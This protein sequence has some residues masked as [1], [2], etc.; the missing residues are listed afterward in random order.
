VH[1][2]LLPSCNEFGGT[3]TGADPGAV[4]E[5]A[6]AMSPGSTSEQQSGV[7]GH[8]ATE[9]NTEESG[10]HS[11]QKD[12]KGAAPED[13]KSEPQGTSGG[14]VEG[15]E[16]GTTASDAEIQ[17]QSDVD[18]HPGQSHQGITASQTLSEVPVNRQERLFVALGGTAVIF[19]I[20]SVAILYWHFCGGGS[21]HSR[22]EW[23]YTELIENK[24]G[25]WFGLDVDDTACTDGTETLVSSA[26]ARS[27]NSTRHN[28]LETIP[29]A[30]AA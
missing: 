11:T 22:A 20:I 28:S 7:S 5:A 30:S 23:D 19:V 24:V 18:Q 3:V 12:A 6:A 2:R 25:R 17:A 9:P 1:F 27:A 21:R 29:L 4:S 15:T 8:S 14:S 26:R 13:L 16:H 10:A